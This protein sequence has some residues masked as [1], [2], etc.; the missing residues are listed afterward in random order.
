MNR[1]TDG[2]YQLDIRIKEGKILLVMA[3]MYSLREDT[4]LSNW[5]LKKGTLIDRPDPRID[6]LEELFRKTSLALKEYVKA[7]VTPIGSPKPA[8]ETEGVDDW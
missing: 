5:I 8:V 6:A 1:L 7:F 4:Y 3:D 2:Y